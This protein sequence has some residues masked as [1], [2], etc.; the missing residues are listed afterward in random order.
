[1]TCGIIRPAPQVLFDRVKNMFSTTVLGGAEVIPESNEWYV[2]ANDYAM[3]EQFSAIAEQMWRETDPRYACCENL[4]AMAA[5]NGVFPR[6]AMFAQTY[7]RLTGVPNT[8][9]P[10][11]LEFSTNI[12]EF[13]SVGTIPAALNASGIA[14]VRAKSLVPGAAFNAGGDQIVTGTLTTVITG[15]DGD[16]EICGGFICGGQDA[17]TCEQ[18]RARYLQRLAYKPRATQG[19]L[20]EQMLSYPCAT[21]VCRREG[22]CCTCTQAATEDCACVAC[23]DALEFYVFFDNSFPC[24]IPDQNII[25]DM[26]LWMFGAEPFQGMGLVEIGICGKIYRPKPFTV[27]LSIDIEGCPTM[28]QKNMI[29][30]EV[31]DFFGTVCPS[32][33]VRQKTIDMIVANIMGIT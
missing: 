7:I 33:V 29:V 14:V 6:P 1:M 12:G 27:D 32:V 18:F 2:V 15:V 11:S 22:S 19:W 28:A 24:G 31:T 3:Q 5:R 13:I 30:S 17:E 9:L 20:I 21:R 10:N 25:D 23:D 26:N 4:Y 8:A 16:V